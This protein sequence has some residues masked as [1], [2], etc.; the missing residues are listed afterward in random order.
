MKALLY[1]AAVLCAIGAGLM[2]LNAIPPSEG[3]LAA[4]RAMATL[5][6]ERYVPRDAS[7]ALTG[8]VALGALGLLFG[9][10]AAVLQRMDRKS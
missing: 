6:G 5:S 8:A 10:G 1:T 3:Q 4:E 2:L 9:F 7:D